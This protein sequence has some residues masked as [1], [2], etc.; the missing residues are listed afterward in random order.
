VTAFALALGAPFW[1]DLL[2]K[3]SNLRGAGRRD[4]PKKRKPKPPA[5]T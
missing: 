4:E 3:V 2:G 1:F 5:A